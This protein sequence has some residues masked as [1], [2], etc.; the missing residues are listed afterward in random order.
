[1]RRPSC[2]PAGAPCRSCAC[3]SPVGVRRGHTCESGWRARAAAGAGVR[4]GE[5]QCVVRRRMNELF[6]LAVVDIRVPPLGNAMRRAHALVSETKRR[7][8]AHTSRERASGQTSCCASCVQHTLGCS[9]AKKSR[10]QSRVSPNRAGHDNHPHTA[11]RLLFSKHRNFRAFFFLYFF[12]L[13]FL[14]F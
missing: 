4:F 13:F 8:R 5:R 11:Q 6:Q 3:E 9:S 1:M 14:F 2:P 12:F 10:S 7:L